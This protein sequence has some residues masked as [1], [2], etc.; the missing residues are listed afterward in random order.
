MGSNAPNITSTKNVEDKIVQLNRSST[1]WARIM[2][3]VGICQLI[4]AVAQIC[5]AWQMYK[6]SK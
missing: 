5:L 1:F 2:S 3:G 6:L 4:L